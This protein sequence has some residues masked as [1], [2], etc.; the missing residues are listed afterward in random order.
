LSICSR[1]HQLDSLGDKAGWWKLMG[2]GSR[3]KA[4][5]EELGLTQ[6]QLAQSLGVTPQHI[7]VIEKDKR[8]PSLESLAK[9][10]LELGITTD[11]LI[12]GKQT[13]LSDCVSVIKADD[14]LTLEHKNA[15]VSIIKALRNKTS[16]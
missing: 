15:L 12:T 13:I 2:L 4:R 14:K 10:A 6:L 1:I 9:L 11:F 5:R 3:I 16:E 8:S 7:S